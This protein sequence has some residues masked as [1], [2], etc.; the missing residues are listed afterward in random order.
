[1]RTRGEYMAASLS[2]VALLCALVAHMA[3][4]DDIADKFANIAYF[5]TI[6]AIIWVAIPVGSI[7]E[8]LSP[9]LKGSSSNTNNRR[10]SHNN[11]D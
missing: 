8:K 4:R 2:L 5:A 10:R 6:L 1:M 11:S 7:R 3:G 9:L